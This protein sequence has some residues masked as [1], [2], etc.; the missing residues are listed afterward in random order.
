MQDKLQSGD[1]LQK[2]LEKILE[3]IDLMY[4]KMGD[5]L[6]N[7]CING[8]YDDHSG[9][10]DNWTNGFWPGILWLTYR[11]TGK[12]CY[13]KRARHLEE[14]MDEIFLDPAKYSHDAGFIWLLSAVAD[15]RLTGNEEAAKRGLRAAYILAGRFNPAGNFIRAWEGNAQGMEGYAII[16]CMMNLPLLYWASEYTKDPRFY[17]IAVRHAQTAARY[18]IREDGSARHI[19]VF[20][21]ESG[22]YLRNLG[23]QGYDEHSAWSRGNAWAVYGFALAYQYTGRN[24][25]LQ[26]ACRTAAFFADHL[27]SDLV[28]F[29][30]FKA[31]QKENLYKDSS[32]AAIAASGLALL[33]GLVDGEEGKKYL[34]LAK[35]IVE[36]LYEHYLDAWESEAI[37]CH[38]CAAYHAKGAG[39]DMGII[40]GDYYFVEALMRLAGKGGLF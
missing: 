4:V 5:K 34:K 37:L 13:Q 38:G 3:K 10:M 32:A 17:H 9:S 35:N 22:E 36:A 8:V 1:K 28:P 16:D 18:F 12:E 19:C 21:A 20:D 30:D 2:I 33:G 15:Y 7:G 29:A 25:F 40:F 24:E 6:P 39:Q 26:T 27:P 31:P 14:K 23:G 11:E